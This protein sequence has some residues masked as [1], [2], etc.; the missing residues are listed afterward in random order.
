MQEAS[1]PV[2]EPTRH[3]CRVRAA[4]CRV[5]AARCRVRAAA[6]AVTRRPAASDATPAA[7]TNGG[8]LSELEEDLR[9]LALQRS[10]VDDLSFAYQLQ[11]EEVMRA[12]AERAGLQVSPRMFAAESE[13]CVQRRAAQVNLQQKVGLRVEMKTSETVLLTRTAFPCKA[14][15]LTCDMLLYLLAR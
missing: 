9:Q 8:P 12:S 6:G 5:R 3:V 10:T 14:K 4:R 13:E 15:S 11:L 7:V 2:E 1:A